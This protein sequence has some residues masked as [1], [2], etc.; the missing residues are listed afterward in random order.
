[1]KKIY[2]VLL[3]I[4]L[5]CFLYTLSVILNDSVDLSI[6]NAKS[7]VEVEGWDK[8]K[9]AKNVYQEM[10]KYAQ[11]NGVNLHKIVFGTDSAGKELKKVFTFSA[12]DTFRY[13]YDYTSFHTKV[14]FFDSSELTNENVM[15]SYVLTTSLP[16][17]LK[18]DFNSLGLKVSIEKI[19][20][21]LLIFGSLFTTV[22]ILSVVLIFTTSLANLFYKVSEMKKYAIWEM[23]GKNIILM[24]SKQNLWDILIIICVITIFICL[25][26]L[27]WKMYIIVGILSSICTYLFNIVTILMVSR[28]EKLIDKIKGKKTSTLPIIL[29][30]VLKMIVLVIFVVFSLN[31]SNDLKKN[32]EAYRSLSQW[33]K[34]GKYYQLHFSKTTELF[35]DEAKSERERKKQFIEINKKLY[36]LL[37]ESEKNGAILSVNNEHFLNELGGS[38]LYIDSVPFMTINH[39]F[40]ETVSIIDDSGKKIEQLA[41]DKFYVLIPMNE[42]AQRKKIEQEVGEVLSLY[43]NLYDESASKFKGNLEI[44]YIKSNQQIFNFNA[45]YPEYSLSKNPIILIVS[46]NTIGPNVGN[47]IANISQGHYLF[48]NE[49]K[50]NQFIEKNN[51]EEEFFGLISA[52]DTAMNMLKKNRNEYSLKIM[53]L[54][55]LFIIFI[56]IEF[57]ISVSYI[58]LNKKRLFLQYIFGVNFFVRHYLYCLTIL[59]VSAGVLAVLSSMNVQYLLIAGG[60]LVFET[61]LLI[62]T[63][64]I[65]EKFKRLDSIKKEN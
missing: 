57:Y 33:G 42:K 60:S 36:P 51:L 24:S 55:I 10:K 26:P 44:M 2:R 31:L 28:T 35:P 63:I 53:S 5:L 47:L 19:N 25:H 20:P 41:D 52:K 46:L 8:E 62:F 34:I 50:V 61:I 27:F 32:N 6:P 43:Q 39:N 29:N 58:E 16:Q 65:S 21:L 49:T 22:G 59:L 7:T 54:F 37:E 30:V 23:N 17:N 3:I 56:L 48:S 11:K 12:D 64:I 9:S 18:D 40:L 38:T 45:E 1:M 4:T 15:G 14:L 13:S